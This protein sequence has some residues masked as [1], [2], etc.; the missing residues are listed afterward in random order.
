MP[1]APRGPAAS[2]CRAWSPPSPPSPA[3]ACSPGRS[4]GLAAEGSSR[5]AGRP[6]HSPRDLGR[7]VA[8]EFGAGGSRRAKSH[9][10]TPVG[11]Q[12]LDR[13]PALLVS[14]LPAHG[15]ERVGAF[16]VSGCIGLAL[17]AAADERC[18]GSGRR[19]AANW[20]RSV[21]K[22]ELGALSLG[23][24]PVHAPF[25]D[26]QEVRPGWSVHR[27]AP[28]PADRVRGNVPGPW[29]NPV[30]PARR[31]DWSVGC[32]PVWRCCGGTGGRGCAPTCSPG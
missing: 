14:R 24:R 25:V 18:N 16:A 10:Q 2:A 4:R 27:A 26:R 20:A 8:G 1:P 32:C 7:D 28:S 11:T 15:L 3:H 21:S 17:E 12:A 9:H 13:R 29:L 5:A 31:R 30:L 23:Y 19:V 22:A 6:R